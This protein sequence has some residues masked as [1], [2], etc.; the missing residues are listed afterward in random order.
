[1]DNTEKSL[2]AHNGALIQV[3]S[4]GF[5]KGNFANIV[6]DGQQVHCTKNSSGH[7]RGLHVVLYNKTQGKAVFSKVFDTYKSSE[8]LEDFIARYEHNIE[9]PENILIVACKDECTTGLS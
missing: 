9:R 8:E 5:G 2:E 7:Y 1:M 4:A 3:K 6:V